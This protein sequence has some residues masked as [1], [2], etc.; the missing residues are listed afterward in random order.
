MKLYG[1]IKDYAFTDPDT[2]EEETIRFKASVNLF[3]LYKSYF[4]RDLLSDIIDY[5]AKLGKTAKLAD[6]AK[7][8]PEE[9]IIELSK[10]SGAEFDMTFVLNILVAMRMNALPAAERIDAETSYDALPP[11]LLSDKDVLSE[12]MELVMKFVAAEKKR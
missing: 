9:A 1:Y 2:G 3:P 4:G 11:A 12:I 6:I 8:S 5:A 7:L 10:V